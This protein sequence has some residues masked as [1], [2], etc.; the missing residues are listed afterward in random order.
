MKFSVKKEQLLPL[1]T[2]VNNIIEKKSTQKIR[3]HILINVTENQLELIGFDSEIKISGIVPATVETVGST[4]VTSQKLFDI[5]RSLNTAADIDIALNDNTL[6]IFSGHSK[7]HL[8]TIP[9]E[10]YPVPDSYDFEQSFSLPANRLI[11]LLNLVKFSMANNDVRHYLN[12][13][14][15]HFTATDLVAVSTDGHRLSIAEIANTFAIEDKKTIIPRK[16]VH[17]VTTWLNGQTGDVNIDISSTHIRFVFSQVEMTS[18]LINAEYPAYETVI[19]TVADKVITIPNTE[20]Q[21]ALQRAR[22]LSSEYGVGVS[23]S[24]M[25]WKLDL[26]AKNM[27]NE[28]VEDSIDINYDGKAIKTAFNINY[29]MD[30]LNVVDNDKVTFSLQNG[31]SSC[32]I[33]D[34]DKE[35]ARYVVMPMNI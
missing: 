9:A 19:P 16:A 7:F 22:I 17:E 29:L 1:L 18:T 27:D 28:S 34:A 8:A 33:Y 25:P 26:L 14:L 12:G 6:D 4:T 32:L 13:L 15:L 11:D 23:L 30:I 10:E 5:I 20:M 3:T 35:N 2:R 24:F 21:Q 31:Q